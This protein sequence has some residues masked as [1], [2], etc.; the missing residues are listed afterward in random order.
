MKCGGYPL[1]TYWFD[2]E[3]GGMGGCRCNESAWTEYNEN[4]LFVW[5]EVVV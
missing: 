4:I 1:E 5:D 3:F 2:V